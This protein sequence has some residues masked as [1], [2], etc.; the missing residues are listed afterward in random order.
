[1]GKKKLTKPAR[2]AILIRI[3]PWM[4]TALKAEAK[5]SMIPTSVNRL[6]VEALLD[7]YRNISV[8]LGAKVKGHE[9]PR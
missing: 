7:K 8:S 9:L 1:M 4:Y 5:A 6:V 3:H 2:R